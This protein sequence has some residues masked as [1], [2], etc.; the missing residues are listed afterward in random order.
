MLH[1]HHPL[2]GRKTAIVTAAPLSIRVAADV[3]RFSL[4]IDPSAIDGASKAFGLKLP[5][6]I[7][8]LA[9]EGEKR[10]VCLGPDEWCLTAPLAEQEA[11]EAAFAGLYAKTIHSLV[12]IGHREVGI[13]VEGAAAALALRSAIAFDIEAMPAGTGCRTIFD[14]AQI[15]LLRET[16]QRFRI[17]VWR[18][19]ADH[20]WGLLE[21]ASHEIALD[22]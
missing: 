16:E 6:T 9:V 1:E 8:G 14:K 7:G 4:R 13:E 3:A 19:F 21:A 5:A 22:I 2:V 10:A 20:V 15:V 12:E 17:E 11:V 18:T